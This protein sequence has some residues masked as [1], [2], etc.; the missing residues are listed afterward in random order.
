[1]K[2]S[3]EEILQNVPNEVQWRDI[4]DFDDFNQ[5]M[6]AVGVLYSNT[7][8]VCD[9]Y[10][11]FIPDNSP[12]LQEEVLS[13]IWTCRPDLANEILLIEI[14]ENF[15]VLIES[16]KNLEMEKFWKHTS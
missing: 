2:G 8:G 12:P 15:R 10:M 14:S 16:Y 4:V 13:W 3:L 5:R 7:I 11:E 1:M 6:E 9:Q